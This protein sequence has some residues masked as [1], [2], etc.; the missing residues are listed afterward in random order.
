MDQDTLHSQRIG[1]PAGMLAA[2]PAEAGER[3]AGYVMASSDRDLA[4]RRGHIVDRNMQ[5]AF[6][7]LLQ[8]LRA[9]ERIRNLLQ[10]RP[11]RRGID[12]LIALRPEDRGE[13]GWIDPSQAEVAVGDGER[14]AGA[15][16]GRAWPRPGRLRADAEAHA[17]KPADR[18]A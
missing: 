6:G 9:A 5:E 3:V 4:D 14:A 10:P 2:C 7:N 15:V 12:R 16:A 8:A 13:F 18:P 17:V 11:R 1:H